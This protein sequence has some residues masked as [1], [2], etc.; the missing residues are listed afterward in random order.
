AGPWVD[1][2]L[3][4]AVGKNDA[5]NVRLV[6]GSHIV[7]PKIHQGDQAYIFQHSDGR[8][9]FALPYET[10]FTLIGTTDKDF[11]GTDPGEAECSPEEKAYLCE[12]A[13]SYFK[14]PVVENDVVW[15]YSGVRPLYDDHASS[16][17]AATREYV[18]K[19]NETGE[20]P[21]L[22]I[23]GGKITTYRRLA[24][25][26]IEKFDSFFP[27]IGAE[28]TKRVPLPGGD[29]A[30]DQ[31]DEL[32]RRLQSRLP[33]LDHKTTHRLVRAYGTDAEKIY[34]NATKKE[35]LGT[36]FGHGI[37]AGEL[38]WVIANEWVMTAEDYLWRRT[39]MGLHVDKQEAA[40][41]DAYIA[42]RIT[43]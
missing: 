26:A 31:F 17:T 5:K 2:L 12:V 43:K 7:V 34:C 19:L 29:F 27:N 33:F 11:E 9:I 28:W 4:T 23:F 41:I 18:L 22:N 15:T 1:K 40:Q 35:D 21:A 38:D 36:N 20:A 37:Y 25:A 3:Q 10:D 42:E 6:Q 24:E 13:S 8:V 16:S 14:K 30:H 39:K 32:V